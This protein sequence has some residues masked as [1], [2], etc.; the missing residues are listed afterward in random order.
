MKKLARFLAAAVVLGAASPVLAQS[1]P[2]ITVTPYLAVNAFGSP[3]YQ[4]QLA[5]LYTALSTG[6]SSAGTA[7]TPTYFQV[8]SNIYTTDM[9]VTNFASY[10]GSA[11]P[12]ATYGSAYASELGTRPSFGLVVNG[13][14]TQF[15]ISQLSFGVVGTGNAG[16]ADGGD[17]AAGHYLDYTRTGFNYG[18][19]Y[20][21]ILFGADHQ[22]GGGDDTY[23]T[24]GSSS[25]QVDMLVGRGT[26]TGYSV[27]CGTDTNVNFGP[28]TGSTDDYQSYIDGAA[29]YYPF[30]A[31]WTGTYTLNGATGS[32][33]FNV[34]QAPTPEPAT[35]GMV[36]LG[37]GAVG[38]AMRRRTVATRVTFA[39]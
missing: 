28:C 4:G 6:Q 19:G 14:G 18:D 21:G 32:G 15:S 26:G 24:S 11:T 38:F 22:L 20:T 1:S 36:I 8:Q 34:T 2:T 35:W 9:L 33:A 7:G 37:M 30:P 13:N 17:Y 23:V 25:Q 5:N 39:A 27:T 16:T 31:T 3:S 10:R 29:L 12:A